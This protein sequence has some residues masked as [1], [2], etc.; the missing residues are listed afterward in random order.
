MIRVNRHRL[1]NIKTRLLPAVVRLIVG[2]VLIATGGCK[3]SSEE[4]EFRR[5]EEATEKRDYEKALGHYAALVDRYV[6]TPLAVRAAR[7]A[8]RILH[9]VQKRP[10]EA[11]RFYKHVVLYASDAEER[12]DAQR[13]IA[14]IFLTE[15]MDY[16]QAIAEYSRLLELNPSPEQELAY[17]LAIARSY[18]YLSKFYQAQV[19]TENIL[20]GNYDK[21]LLFEA[22]LLKANIFLASKKLD[23]A[24]ALLK[25]LM[26]EYPERSK[27]ENI[28]FVLAV[29]YEDKKD[30]KSAIE[31]LEAMKETYPGKDFIEQR[32]KILRERQSHLPGA[33]GWR[34]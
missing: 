14:E 23:E 25:E 5:A 9:Y 21:K 27:E 34:K 15:T 24:V 20:R 6:E 26:A 17:R 8:A 32:I 29:T 13:K 10:K 11:I 18:F 1:T 19:E 31:T 2:C 30:F 7:E 33:R 28:G 12:T 16:T 22:L 3:F 4:L